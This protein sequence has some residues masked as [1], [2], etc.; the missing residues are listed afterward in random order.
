MMKT[1]EE[2]EME[3]LQQ[4]EC[5]IP[6]AVAEYTEIISSPQKDDPNIVTKRTVFDLQ[7]EEEADKKI[8]KEHIKNISVGTSGMDNIQPFAESQAQSSYNLP[9]CL[10]AEEEHLH[11]NHHSTILEKSQNVVTLPVQNINSSNQLCSD[12]SPTSIS[13]ETQLSYS[14][15][16]T[17]NDDTLSCLSHVSSPVNSN[18]I[19]TNYSRQNSTSSSLKTSHCL[20]PCRICG[21]KASGFHYGVNTCEACKD[22]VA[23]VNVLLA[24]YSTF[25]VTGEA[26]YNTVLTSTSIL[27]TA[28]QGFDQILDGGLYTGEVTEIAGEIASGKTQI[29][30]SMTASVICHSK[31]NV[32]YVDTAGGFSGE[33]L[34]EIL[35]TKYQ[36]D[37]LSELQQ[38]KVNITQQSDPFYACL[39]L[40]IIDNVASVIYPILGGNQLDGHG[41][42]TQ[43]SQLL[44]LLAVDYSLSVLVSNNVVVS[45]GEKKASLG[46]VWSHVPHTRVLVSSMGDQQ[47][48]LIL[49]KS[50]RSKTGQTANFII[51]E[52]GCVDPG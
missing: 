36:Q 3:L 51:C 16:D 26:L 5:D 44:K 20:P 10:G 12:Y 17:D 21:E 1:L 13:Q 43:L 47:R 34:E 39:K 11:I 15:R 30:L 50:S 27:P 25:P 37:L 6:N 7:H 8:E 40:I 35:H 18:H 19:S 14:S 4:V 46:K 2:E 32:M 24:Q 31:Q 41:L 52:K 29:C 45:D 28:C 9:T 38:I 48:Q 49:V 42:I 23:I 33:R 22:L